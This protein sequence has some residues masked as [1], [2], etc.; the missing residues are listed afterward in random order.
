MTEV[1]SALAW[2]Q[3]LWE[4]RLQG[5]AED[6]FGSDGHVRYRECGVGYMGLYICQNS[7][8]YTLKNVF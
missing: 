6:L 2:C 4:G 7:W 8:N 5:G 1:R 3:G